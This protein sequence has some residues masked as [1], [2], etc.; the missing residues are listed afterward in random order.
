MSVT[1][2]VRVYGELQQKPDLSFFLA[3]GDMRMPIGLALPHDF[4]DILYPI[5]VIC[6]VK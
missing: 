3:G 1:M 6:M 2:Y 4:C 5:V